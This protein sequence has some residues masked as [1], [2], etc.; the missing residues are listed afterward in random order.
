MYKWGVVVS[1]SFILEIQTGN[2]SKS[3]TLW[4]PLQ[5]KNWDKGDAEFDPVDVS[6]IDSDIQKKVLRWMNPVNQSGGGGGGGPWEKNVM[7]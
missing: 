5:K 4:T 1:W 2:F 7:Q 6:G 3:V